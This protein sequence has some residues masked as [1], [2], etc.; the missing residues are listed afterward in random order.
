MIK[1]T[2]ENLDSIITENKKVVIDCFAEWCAP[3]KM[4]EPVLKEMLKKFGGKIIFGKLNIDENRE[5]VDKF[6]IKSIPTLLL[7]SDGKL[8]DRIIGAQT[9]EV[10]EETLITKNMI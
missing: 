1:I 6:N 4:I 10:I 2:K 5:M 8:V 7:F 9:K 3:C